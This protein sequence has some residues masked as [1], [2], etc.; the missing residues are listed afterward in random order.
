MQCSNAETYDIVFW[1]DNERR[2]LGLGCQNYAMIAQNLPRAEVLKNRKMTGD[3]VV[4]S[5]TFFVVEDDWWLFEFEKSLPDCY[6]KEQQ[7][8]YSL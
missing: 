8:L 5:G 1:H 7:R 4:Y 2:N 3:V 6:A